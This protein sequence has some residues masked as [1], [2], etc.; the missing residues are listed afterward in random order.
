MPV[1]MF[2]YGLNITLFFQNSIGGKTCNASPTSTYYLVMNYTFYRRVFLNKD[3]SVSDV[4][5]TL[6]FIILL[7]L[8]NKTN[9]TRTEYITL[10][11]LYLW[12][13]YDPHL[14]FNITCEQPLKD[15]MIVLFFV[16]KWWQFYWIV[17][18]LHQGG[19]ATCRA[20]H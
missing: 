20:T 11:L 7:I 9:F 12:A 4:L 19:C 18:E 1:N 14:L 13:K 2:K 10:L 3:F 5:L 8:N 16:Q 15:F 17:M 6:I